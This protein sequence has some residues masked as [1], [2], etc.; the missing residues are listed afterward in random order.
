M[1]RKLERLWK[2]NKGKLDRSLSSYST[3]SPENS[4]PQEVRENNEPEAKQQL[5]KKSSSDQKG[6][7][8]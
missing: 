6:S 4:S 2:K 1:K 8:N 3:I 7:V 5:I